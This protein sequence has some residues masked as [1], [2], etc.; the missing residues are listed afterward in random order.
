MKGNTVSGSSATRFD[1][2][3]RFAEIAAW[4]YVN[5]HQNPTIQIN[6]HA[7]AGLGKEELPAFSAM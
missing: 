7:A 6:K 3:R 5:H 2:R 4:F 1:A